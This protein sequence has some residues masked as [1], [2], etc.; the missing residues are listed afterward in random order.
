M[1]EKD[2]KHLRTDYNKHSLS[3]EDAGSNPFE[4]F[5]I[6]FNDAV[7]GE[8]EPNSMVLSTGVK[9]PT[10]RV[11]LLKEVQDNAFVFF[12][13]YNSQKGRDIANNGNVSLLF[14]WQN[15]ERQV[16]IEGFATKISEQESND[17]FYSRPL[18][19]QIGAI[20]SSQSE[21]LGSR[22]E[23]ETQ[24][25]QLTELYKNKPIERP[26]NWGGYAVEPALFEFWQGR[27]S[28]LHDRLQ[29]KVDQ[30]DW[31]RQRLYP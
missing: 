12:T 10:S 21:V 29:F 3:E 17:Y 8:K 15:L 1:E 13:N 2:L 18:E 11:V 27:S 20:A 31:K 25:K 19:S 26:S 28:R 23:L 7:T 4:L 9:Q 16:R 24:V 22:L 30:G 6:W 14:Y 5:S